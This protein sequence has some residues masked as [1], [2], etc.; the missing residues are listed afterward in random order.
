MPGKVS[1]IMS[2]ELITVK[3]PSSIEDAIRIIMQHNVTG[4]PVVDSSGKYQGMLSRKDIFQSPNDDQTAMVMRKSKALS[5]NTTIKEAALEL[6]RYGRRHIA[7]TDSENKVVG[8]LTPQNFLD[9]IGKH[10]G[11]V[12]VSRF[13]TKKTVPVWEGTPISVV[14]YTTQLTELY[15]FPVVNSDGDFVGIVTDRDLFNKVDFKVETILSDTGIAD[16]EDPWTWGGIR[17]FVTYLIRKNNLVLPDIPASEV[18]IREPAT[19]YLHDTIG[20]ATKTMK[21]RNFNQLPVLEGHNRIAGM[22]YDI[23]LLEVFA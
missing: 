15:A 8:I 2:T 23:N 3:V 18:M 6:T 12:P 22:L 13:I 7:V 11:D 16:D 10:Y 17:N 1:D 4:V 21:E 19:I 20:E 9:E 14:H 5:E